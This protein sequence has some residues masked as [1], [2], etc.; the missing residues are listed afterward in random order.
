MKFF[1]RVDS[2]G[3]WDAVPSPIIAETAEE[4]A[5]I[6]VRVLGVEFD[7]SS[8]VRVEVHEITDADP[9]AVSVRPALETI[10]R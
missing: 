8:A 9:V 10:R 6:G 2:F 7:V 1:V 5:A 3:A 4:A